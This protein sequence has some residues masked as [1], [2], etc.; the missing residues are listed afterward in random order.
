[1]EIWTA[2]GLGYPHREMHV[3]WSEITARAPHHFDAHSSALQYWTQ[4]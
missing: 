3:L 2:L 1:M 4:Y